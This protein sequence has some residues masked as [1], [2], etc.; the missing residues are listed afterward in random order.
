MNKLGEPIRIFHCI[1]SLSNHRKDVYDFIIVA[2]FELYKFELKI[3]KM[4]AVKINVSYHYL[5]FI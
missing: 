1:I 2:I 5:Y 3:S 4:H